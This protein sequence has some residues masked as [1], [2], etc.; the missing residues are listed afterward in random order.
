MLRY[1]AKMTTIFDDKRLEDTATQNCPRSGLHRNETHTTTRLSP[2]QPDNTTWENT[3]KVLGFTVASTRHLAELPVVNFTTACGSQLERWARLSPATARAVASEDLQQN[4][5]VFCR[6]TGPPK[7]G[8]VYRPAQHVPEGYRKGSS[9]TERDGCSP[10]DGTT[11][12]FLHALL[13]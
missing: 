4:P 11:I 6:R 12:P 7:R 3:W 8:A 9:V 10:S 1:H 13:A 5:R 2:D